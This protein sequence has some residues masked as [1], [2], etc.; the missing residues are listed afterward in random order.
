MP[1]TKNRMRMAVARLYP[2]TSCMG[3]EQTEVSEGS[4]VRPIWNK[5]SVGP[6]DVT[7]N[8]TKGTSSP[9]EG[10]RGL[11]GSHNLAGGDTGG[12]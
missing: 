2:R 10:Q 5:G 7:D 1:R 12:G 4:H 8:R 11:G 3:Q 9:T 6:G